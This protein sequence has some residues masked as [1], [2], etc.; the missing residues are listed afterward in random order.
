[1]EGGTET[2]EVVDL[3][4][5]TPLRIS[6]IPNMFADS[7][8]C[9]WILSVTLISKQQT[10]ILM[11]IIMKEEN[12]NR[13]VLIGSLD[14]DEHRRFPALKLADF[15]L[16]CLQPADI[17]P[18][19]NPDWVVQSQWRA[20]PGYQSPVGSSR[21]LCFIYRRNRLQLTRKYRRSKCTALTRIVIL[22]CKPA[23]G[24]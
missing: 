17:D 4:W 14:S 13:S 3:A 20:T 24:L 19:Q 11:Q 5:G 22:A 23:C 16:S 10:V 15:G 6:W 1:M 21:S 9:G 8:A 2:P 18:K 12:T 7:N